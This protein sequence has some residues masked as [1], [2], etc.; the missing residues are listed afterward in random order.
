MKVVKILKQSQRALKKRLRKKE[1]QLDRSNS[2]P[3][4]IQEE[5]STEDIQPIVHTSTN[6]SQNEQTQAEY[7]EQ[8]KDEYSYDAELADPSHSIT[9]SFDFDSASISQQKKRKDEDSLSS[10]QEIVSAK[11]N[12]QKN[13][14]LVDILIEKIQTQ[15]D[16]ASSVM[17]GY[18]PVE[19]AR[20]DTIVAVSDPA[21][22]IVVDEKRDEQNEQLIEDAVDQIIQRVIVS[23]VSSPVMAQDR[24]EESEINNI[25]EETR[26][27]DP[28]L[29]S[30]ET[31]RVVASHSY[32]L[33][34]D[35]ES[36]LTIHNDE[37]DFCSKRYSQLYTSSTDVS[38]KEE[39]VIAEDLCHMEGSSPNEAKEVAPLDEL[40]NSNLP[41]P[42]HQDQMLPFEEEKVSP[43]PSPKYEFNSI[44]ESEENAKN[45]IEE[46]KELHVSTYGESI[47]EIAVR[48]QEN[49]YIETPLPPKYATTQYLDFQVQNDMFSHY[50]PAI[51]WK[52]SE[53]SV[54]QYDKTQ[55][56]TCGCHIM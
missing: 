38:H 31:P 16:K 36:E 50:E 5:H 14:Q 17:N 40:M 25:L 30:C 19:K 13:N 22:V 46:A 47:I 33:T 28:G 29:L 53:F 6:L 9:G 23:N 44:L 34:P 56:Q 42:P 54:D 7:G 32:P 12:E 11:E 4:S 52:S 1:Q 27:C 39:T 26:V 15:D 51:P 48:E 37:D 55:R 3:G 10:N 20:I 35:P 43:Q 45:S 18:P 21:S 2:S 8:M 24:V 41:I 49:I